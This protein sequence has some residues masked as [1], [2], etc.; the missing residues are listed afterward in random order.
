M[1]GDTIAFGPGKAA[2][3]QA[4]A[5]SG[6]IAA[7]AREM[8]MSYRRAWLLVEEMNH[9]FCQP[10]VTTTTG[11]AR[12]GGARI[13]ALAHEVIGRYEQM[14]KKADSAIQEDMCYLLSLVVEKN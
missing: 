10:L 2:L 13:T 9:C 11:G 5:R 8:S 1:Q 4:I 12:G 14:Q 3:L 6:S 7:A